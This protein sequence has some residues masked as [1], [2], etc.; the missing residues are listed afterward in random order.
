VVVV[1]V[2]VNQLVLFRALELLEFLELRV[3][4]NAF[5]LLRVISTIIPILRFAH[6]PVITLLLLH[7]QIIF[8]ELFFET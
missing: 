3:L 1:D 5:L 8:E 4:S 7:L 2:L 6:T